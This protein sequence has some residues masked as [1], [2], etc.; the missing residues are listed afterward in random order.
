MLATSNSPLPGATRYLTA[1]SDGYVDAQG[2]RLHVVMGNQRRN[3]DFRTHPLRAP[4]LD[5][6]LYDHLNRAVGTIVIDAMHLTRLGRFFTE[7]G[8]SDL[9]AQV[10]SELLE[11]LREQPGMRRSRQREVMDGMSS[12]HTTTKLLAEDGQRATAELT[13]RLYGFG[14]AR[15]PPAPGWT[16]AVHEIMQEACSERFKASW[17]RAAHEK[18]QTAVTR[19]E[20]TRLLRAIRME[21]EECDAVLASRVFGDTAPLGVS[22]PGPVGS[23]IDPNPYICFALLAA[24][25]V[26]L[27]AAEL[28][29][30]CIGDDERRPGLLYVH[31]AN[32]PSRYLPITPEMRRALDLV[33]RWSDGLREHAIDRS[34]LLVFSWGDPA[35]TGRLTGCGAQGVRRVTSG[36]LNQ[37]WLPNFYRKYFERTELAAAEAEVTQIASHSRSRS[38]VPVLYAEPK[39][40]REALRPLAL[41]Y[42]DVR[43]AGLTDRSKDERN[44]HILQKHAGHKRFSTTERYYLEQEEEERMRDT[45]KRL[46]PH[47]ERLRMRMRNLVVADPNAEEQASLAQ[48]G[49][50][51]PIMRGP[52]PALGGHC[53]DAATN[54]VVAAQAAGFRPG[55]ARS[56]DCRLCEHFRI[57][58]SRRPVYVAARAHTLKQAAE[59]QRLGDLREAENLRQSAALD[60]AIINRIDEYLGGQPS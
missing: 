37:S 5:F 52:Q 47:A 14:L 44:R 57:Y 46:L 21:I 4:A 8:R 29:A 28:N 7:T 3:F 20:F 11:W 39:R 51:V 24:M 50:L 32:K 43:A 25:E 6:L 48:R 13:A 38:L 54:D 16:T 31:A 59:Q 55:C 12:Q 15:T 53:H 33:M 34:P 1:S 35:R 9:T 58:A 2:W 23:S 42:A 45:A 19:D 26:G 18:S 49:A 17:R 56:G 27:R 22:W 10:Y 40:E 30:L 41:A 36:I 60:Q